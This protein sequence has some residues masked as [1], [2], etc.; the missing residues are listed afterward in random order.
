M[1]DAGIIRN[2]LTIEAVIFNAKAI[3][4][5]AYTVLLLSDMRSMRCYVKA[6]DSFKTVIV[7]DNACKASFKNLKLPEK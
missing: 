1:Q 7:K 6:S 5:S 3:N 2:R 4:C